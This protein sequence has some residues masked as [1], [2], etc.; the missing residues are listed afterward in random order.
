MQKGASKML[1]KCWWLANHPSF[2]LQTFTG[3]NNL[4]KLLGAYFGA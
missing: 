3:P 2:V 4:I 1:M